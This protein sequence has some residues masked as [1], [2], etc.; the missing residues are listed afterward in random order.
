[1]IVQ[2]GIDSSELKKTDSFKEVVS[3]GVFKGQCKGG[4]SISVPTNYLYPDVI[5]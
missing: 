4:P 5:L 2:E 1:M 3:I